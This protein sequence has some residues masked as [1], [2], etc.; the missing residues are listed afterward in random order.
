MPQG[1]RRRTSAAIRSGFQDTE[2]TG[3]IITKNARFAVAHGVQITY[4][5]RTLNRV[6]DSP[7]GR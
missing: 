2:K 5:N 1:S 4:M 7:L 3:E 6:P